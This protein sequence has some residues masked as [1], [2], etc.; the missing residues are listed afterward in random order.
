MNGMVIDLQN[1]TVD[2]FQPEGACEVDSP[3]LLKAIHQVFTRV[4]PRWW[5]V[6]QA[7][8]GCPFQHRGKD[9]NSCASYTHLYALLRSQNPPS[10]ILKRDIQS[11]AGPDGSG[12]REWGEC[13]SRNV[14]GRTVLFTGTDLIAH[15]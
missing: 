4:S 15:I 9:H 1:N 7:A 6:R 12:I 13:L 14:M 10:C 11:M 5:K 3:E 8:E 2:V